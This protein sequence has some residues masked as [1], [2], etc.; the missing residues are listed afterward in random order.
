M[1]LFM[2]LIALLMVLTGC[3]EKVCPKPQYPEIRTINKVPRIDIV[4][5][6]GMMDMNSTKKAFKT[7]RALRVSEQYYYS[8]ISDYREE[9]VK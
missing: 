4:V 5:N 8:I 1:L 6:N 9:F 2:I 7:I 3:N